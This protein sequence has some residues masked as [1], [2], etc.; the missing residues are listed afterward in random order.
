MDARPSRMVPRISDVAARAGVSVATVSRVLNTPSAVREDKRARVLHAIDE[1]GFRPS[2]LARGLSVGRTGVIGVIAPF[3]TRS[4]TIGARL[5]GIT[6][7]AVLESYD[8]MIF[9]VETPQQR[10]DAL[11]K[12]ARRDRVDGVVVVSLPLSDA[13]VDGIRREGLPVVLLDVA[14]PRLPHVVID[15]V[16]GGRMATQHLLARGHE[17]IAFVG[18]V[19]EPALGFT[20]SQRRR[21]GY[22]AALDAAGIVPDPELTGLAQHGRES[23][24]ADAKRLLGL[25][26]PP[27]AVFAASD[28]Q[29]LGVL[30]AAE[31]AGRDVPGDLAVIGFDDIEFAEVVGLTTVR[32]PLVEISAAGMRLLVDE[33][34]DGPH[35][36]AE[37]VKPLAL[38]VR[39]T[40]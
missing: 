9:N 29:A 8:V 17:R 36:V 14:H 11:L 40:T 30:Q 15:D 16:A 13:E 28:V 4:A 6:D 35:G 25:A 39:R 12:L 37:I 27:T 34:R 33:L 3:F 38:V 22:R 32:Q 2:S 18:D 10:T 5:R 23:A 20:S 24:R 26:A 31:D 19:P 21:E 7:V 1:L